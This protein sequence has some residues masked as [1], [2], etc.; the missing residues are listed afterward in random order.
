MLEA[1]HEIHIV[2][3]EITSDRRRIAVVELREGK[4]SYSAQRLRILHK[5]LQC[6]GGFQQDWRRIHTLPREDEVVRGTNPIT[7]MQFQAAAEEVV[8]PWLL[9]FLAVPSDD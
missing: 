7:A 1:L 3:V 6:P 9:D 4:A 8:L 2:A 5:F